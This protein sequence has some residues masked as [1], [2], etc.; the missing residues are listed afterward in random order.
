VEDE[1]DAD[2]LVEAAVD[3]ERNDDVDDP[4]VADDLS[5]SERV[6]VEL[7]KLSELEEAPD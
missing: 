2:E 5:E 7:A 6:E 1:A 3:E 4:D